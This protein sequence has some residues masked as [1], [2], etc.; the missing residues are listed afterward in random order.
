MHGLQSRFEFRL[1]ACHVNHGLSSNAEE[2]QSF[3]HRVCNDMRVPLDIVPIDIPRGSAEGLEAAARARRYAAFG[4]LSADWIVLAQHRGDQAET[5]LFNLL[6]GS[7]LGGVAAMSETRELRS[8][9]GLMRPL[10]GVAR[11]EIDA[12][13]MK[14]GLEWVEDESNQDTGFSRNFLRHKVIPLLQSRFPAAEK[15]LATASRH[16]SEAQALLDELALLDLGD[17]PPLFP[18][19]VSCLSRLPEP[20]ARNLLRFLLARHGIRI[21]SGERLLEFVRQLLE[22]KPDRHPAAVFGNMQVRRQ[23]G[24]VYLEPLAKEAGRSQD[25]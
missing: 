7:G 17:R 19:P 1:G 13:L 11:S 24:K 10:L 9:L 20:R 12:Y 18:L 8:G 22:A 14:H 16:F 5:L 3:C 21:P 15:K 4:G 23:R 2:W 6:R 25:V